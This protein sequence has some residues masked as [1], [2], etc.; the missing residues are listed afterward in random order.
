[1]RVLR[2]GCGGAGDG[3]TRAVLMVG[4]LLVDPFDVFDLVRGGGDRSQR[5]A[6]DAD[7]GEAVHDD[8]RVR[9]VVLSRQRWNEGSGLYRACVLGCFDD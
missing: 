3:L 8:D 5:E 7:K 1:M 6:E 4:V 2:P 9:C